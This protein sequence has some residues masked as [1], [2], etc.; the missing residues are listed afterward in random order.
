LKTEKKARMNESVIDIRNA[1][2]AYHHASVLRDVSFQARAGEFTGIIGPNGAGKTTLLTVINGLT[3][4]ASGSAR[5]LGQPV[6][7]RTAYRLRRRIGHVAQAEAIDP[8]LPIT[9]RES[10]LTGVTGRLGLLRRPCAADRHLAEE[11]LARV[12]AAHLADRPLGRLSGG[13]YQRVAIARVLAQQPDI[14]LF[15]E[16]AASIDPRAQEDILAFIQHLHRRNGAA[17]L[18]VTHDLSALPASCERL[19]LMK[20][21]RIWREGPREAM[22]DAALLEELYEGRPAGLAALGGMAWT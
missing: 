4:L 14:F 19:V 10:V 18:Y 13:E 20:E 11:S 7:P 12:G 17:M 6:H 2:V 3:R 1:V 22:L 21:G 5:V 16:P 9:V 8:R 15:D